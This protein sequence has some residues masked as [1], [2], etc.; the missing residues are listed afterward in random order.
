MEDFILDEAKIAQNR[1]FIRKTLSE[2]GRNGMERLLSWLDNTDFYTA[3]ASTKY[4][5]HCE[6]GLA[7]HSINVYELL[8]AKV[9][10]GLIDIKPETVAITALLHDICKANFYVKETRN[11]KIDGVW[12]EVEEWGVNE[13][14]PIGHGDKSCYL[15]QTFMLLSPEEYAMVRFHMGRESDSYSDGFSK[16]AAKY[17]SVAAIHCAD[18]EAAYIVENRM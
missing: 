6:G 11:R 15:I 17:P 9:E 10:A 2:T 13:K 16:A 5:L 3:P 7:Q 4:H 14:L 18:L 12:H 8:K 1:D